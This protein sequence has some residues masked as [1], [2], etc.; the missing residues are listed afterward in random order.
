MR[1]CQFF[2]RQNEAPKE[3]WSGKSSKCKK[4]KYSKNCVKYTIT[5]FIESVEK[6]KRR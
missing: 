5:G 6:K 4:C 3:W 1:N 2:G